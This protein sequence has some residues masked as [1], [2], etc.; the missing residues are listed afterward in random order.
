MPWNIDKKVFEN[1][2]QQGSTDEGQKE[3]LINSGANAVDPEEEEHQKGK[4]LM[5][6]FIS[7]HIFLDWI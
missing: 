2:W 4:N 3:N 1:H 7:E 6:H 5:A